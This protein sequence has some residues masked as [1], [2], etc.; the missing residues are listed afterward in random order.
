MHPALWSFFLLI[1]LSVAT[2]PMDTVHQWVFIDYLWDSE[3]ARQ[4]AIASGQYL[5]THVLPMDVESWTNPPG[6]GDS[7]LQRYPPIADYI[8]FRRRSNDVPGRPRS[9]GHRGRG[10]GQA[11]T[12][13]TP[14]QTLPQLVP[15]QSQSDHL[16]LDF[17]R[18]QGCGKSLG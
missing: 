5:F 12:V 9:S 6:V 1:G 10:Y 3:S 2:H 7:S 8:F 15:L 11:G 18:L 16:Q 4:R 14:D 13:R 17:E